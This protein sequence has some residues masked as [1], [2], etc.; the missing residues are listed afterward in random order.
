MIHPLERWPRERRRPALTAAIVAAVA[1]WVLLRLLDAPLRDTGDG[2][3]PLEVAGS[4]ERAEE[5]LDG[6][7][8][9]DVLANGAFLNGIDL[10]FPPLYVAALAGACIAAAAGWR[11]RG[12]A[13]I[14]AAGIACAW[15]VTAAGVFD[16]IE[17]AALAVVILDEPA[18]P[19]P[20]MA[21]AAAIPKF[22][23]TTAGLVY[24]LLGGLGLLVARF[25]ETTHMG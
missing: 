15:L 12:R 9:D 23:G 25:R 11:R 16:W 6:W 14:A 8:A 17:N 5:I 2:T 18:S 24:G 19:W 7:R 10:L 21:L 4:P 13:G 3:I 20:Q 1:M 22:T